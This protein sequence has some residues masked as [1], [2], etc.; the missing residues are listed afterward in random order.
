M[1]LEQKPAK[2]VTLLRLP[3]VVEIT[4]IPP[5]SV[6]ALVRAG[7]FPRPVALSANR[8]AW[9]PL[10]TSWRWSAAVCRASSKLT[11]G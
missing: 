2:S 1:P 3:H 10:R 6:S 9:I 7:T 11:A 4:K 8:V 5:S